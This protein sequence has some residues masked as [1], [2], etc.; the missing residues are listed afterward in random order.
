MGG[1]AVAANPFV[2]LPS[3]LEA[4]FRGTTALQEWSRLTADVRW[5][6]SPLPAGR[7]APS[8]LPLLPSGQ[9][10]RFSPVF[11]HMQVW[12]RV[13][14]GTLHPSTYVPSSLSFV[15]QNTLSWN[16]YSLQTP[17]TLKPVIT[18]SN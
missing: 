16:S 11:V 5:A 6:G 15:S 10:S 12:V 3:H 17:L 14:S 7:A 4:I 13:P 1:E 9:A 2:V 18:C 8:A